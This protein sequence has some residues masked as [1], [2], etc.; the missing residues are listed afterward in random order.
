MVRTNYE[1]V[2]A[3]VGCALK[4]GNSLASYRRRRLLNYFRALHVRAIT[5]ALSKLLGS[6]FVDD[7]LAGDRLSRGH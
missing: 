4:S 5:S 1:V 7:G 6:D 2:R 3:R